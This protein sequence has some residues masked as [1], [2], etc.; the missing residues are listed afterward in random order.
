[1]IYERLFLVTDIVAQVETLERRCSVFFLP[2]LLGL[3]VVGT[4]PFAVVLSQQIVIFVFGSSG[5]KRLVGRALLFL[6]IFQ[7][8]VFFYSFFFVAE[9]SKGQA[10]LSKSIEIDV[11]HVCLNHRPHHQVVDVLLD[12][13][14]D[15]RLVQN[16][17]DAWSILRFF[18]KHRRNEVSELF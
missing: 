14:F 17:D 6:E 3:L 9:D 5:Q 16:V 7:A 15:E 11:I 13:S 12:S 4:F 8:R 18:G 2:S 10:L 1:M